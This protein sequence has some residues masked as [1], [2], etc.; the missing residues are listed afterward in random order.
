MTAFTDKAASMIAIETL[1][2]RILFIRGARIML[3]TDLTE[4]YGLPTKALNQAVRR[5]IKRFPADFMFQLNK[6]E[7]HEVV[8]NCDN[9]AML[10]LATALSYSFTGLIDAIRQLMTPPAQGKRTIGFVVT[11]TDTG[12]I[13]K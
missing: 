12:L 8:T 1:V 10:K 4:L 3:D 2:Q 11:D 13:K 5:N 6:D 9:L 7:K